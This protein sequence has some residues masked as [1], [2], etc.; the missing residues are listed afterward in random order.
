MMVSLNSSISQEVLFTR[1]MLEQVIFVCEDKEE[2][3]QVS[4]SENLSQESTHLI[5]SSSACCTLF[6]AYFQLTCLLWKRVLNGNGALLFQKIT[7]VTHVTVKLYE[8]SPS[9]V[10]KDITNKIC[11]SAQVLLL[12]G[13]IAITA[14]KGT[15][16]IF[17]LNSADDTIPCLYLS[18]HVGGLPLNV[19]ECAVQ[20]LLLAHKFIAMVRTASEP[21]KSIL[22]RHLYQEL[23]GVKQHDVQRLTKV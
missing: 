9:S 17:F 23:E 7:Y 4:S 3:L 1:W 15:N 21:M 6:W 10:Q 5:S 19:H 18:C 13:Q 20:L 11:S 22:V 12:C 14:V 2:V 16:M 8:Q